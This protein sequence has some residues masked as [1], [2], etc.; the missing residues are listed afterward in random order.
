MIDPINCGTGI[1]VPGQRNNPEACQETLDETGDFFIP[2]VTS[3]VIGVG[4]GWGMKG[5]DKD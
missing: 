1:G 4:V 5:Q 3:L 2:L